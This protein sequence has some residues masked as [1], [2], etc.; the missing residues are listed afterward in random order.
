M[1]KND[2][3]AGKLPIFP[4]GDI[5]PVF[6]NKVSSLDSLDVSNRDPIAVA[7]ELSYRANI[8]DSRDG[9]GPYRGIVL[10]VE[11][12]ISGGKASP[13]TATTWHAPYF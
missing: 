1:A 12:A 7:L 3:R 5:N 6:K 2:N 13:T 8:K 11:S 10:R 9:T 4:Y